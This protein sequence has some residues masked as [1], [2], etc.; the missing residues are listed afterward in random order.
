MNLFQFINSKIFLKNFLISV[1]ITLLLILIL[2][3]S[4][5]Y[6][7]HHGEEFTVPDYIGKLVT[8]LPRISDEGNMKNKIVDSIYDPT[9]EAGTII[10]Q[11]PLPGSK[12]KRDRIIYLTVIAKVPEQVKM[13]DLID[14]SLRQATAMLQSYGLQA[15]KLTFSPDI[16]KN[17]VLKQLF[18][19]ASIKPGTIIH[20]GS[21]I[22][23]VLGSGSADG[24][25]QV[26]FLIGKKQSEALRIL[27]GLHLA[28]GTETFDGS[29][30]TIHSRIYKQEPNYLINSFLNPGEK[31][32][33]WYRSDKTF[34]FDQYIKDFK[35]DTL[36]DNEN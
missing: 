29:K 8:D 19:G 12:V 10:N 31:V 17:A 36:T 27:A 11:D 1:G 18:Q 6:Y 16:A 14:L 23:L 9:R 3:I 34:D 15:G 13:P 4:S 25:I 35:I 26:P 24:Q 5:R 7:T 30:D 21:R 33:V 2:S 20:K 32:N 28:I 22:D